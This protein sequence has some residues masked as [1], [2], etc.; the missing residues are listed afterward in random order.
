MDYLSF[1]E[2][3]RQ[4]G[5]KHFAAFQT[6]FGRA[7]KVDNEKL[8]EKMVKDYRVISLTARPDSILMWS[9]YGKQH[10]GI[11]FK[12]ETEFVVADKDQHDEVIVEVNY[13]PDRAKLP[14][15]LDHRGHDASRQIMMTLTK[16]KYVDWKYEQEYRILVG[17]DHSE[18]YPY[19]PIDARVIEEVVLGMKCDWKTEMLVKELLRNPEFSHV[20][21]KKARIH[22][23]RFSLIYDSV[24]QV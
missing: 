21:L 23:D 7:I 4:D 3:F 12:F 20:V 18:N 5:R 8:Y 6:A 15:R 19:I 24:S 14:A 10:Q 17:F 1:R 2:W 22:P 13:S 9:H 16:T 11:L